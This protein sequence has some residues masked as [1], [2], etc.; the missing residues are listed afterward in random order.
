MALLG[1]EAILGAVDLLHEDV[2]VP[3]WGGTVLMGYIIYIN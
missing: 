1:R 2:D 3:E